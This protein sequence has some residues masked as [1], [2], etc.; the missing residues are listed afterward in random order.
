MSRRISPQHQRRDRREGRRFQHHGVAGQQRGCELPHRQHQRIV[1]R[2]NRGDHAERLP[3]NLDAAILSVREHLGRHLEAGGVLAPDG[4]AHQLFGGLGERL[5]LF[6]G[7]GIGEALGIGLQRGGAF[8]EHLA[9]RLEIAAPGWIR[10]L[11]GVEGL[12]E[13]GFAA[14]R[15]LGED[16]TGGGI[17]HADGLRPFHR[18]AVD[19]HG[20]LFGHFGCSCRW[21]HAK[22]VRPF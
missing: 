7:E 15:H 22:R 13:F 20:V 10:L 9:A 1:P 18:L 14:I 21:G 11:S 12:I 16:F 5:T 17:D 2:G 3:M 19:G 8:V 4:G 6:E